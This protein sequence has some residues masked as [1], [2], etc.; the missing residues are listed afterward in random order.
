[1][2]EGTTTAG[3]VDQEG[4]RGGARGALSG[5]V[6]DG[7]GGVGEPEAGVGGA[8]VD[9]DEVGQS[10]GDHIAGA[11]VDGDRGE[12]AGVGDVEVAA[13]VGCDGHGEVDVG[14]V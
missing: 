11:V 10:R 2:A 8:G 6:L 7:A 4:A 3:G 14:V 9:G 5:E 12:L 1:D 13:G